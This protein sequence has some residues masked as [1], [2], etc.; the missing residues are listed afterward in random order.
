MHI[1]SGDGQPYVSWEIVY[2]GTYRAGSKLSSADASYF[3]F[4]FQF[5]VTPVNTDLRHEGFNKSRKTHGSP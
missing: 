2:P 3:P 4:Y 1:F 5:R